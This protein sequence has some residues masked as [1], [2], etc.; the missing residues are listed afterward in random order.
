MR[1][2]TPFALAAS[3]VVA[4]HQPYHDSPAMLA[5]PQR[6]PIDSTVNVH[7]ALQGNGI[8]KRA[9]TYSRRLLSKNRKLAEGRYEKKYR[10]RCEAGGAVCCVVAGA[11]VGAGIGSVT[12]GAIPGIGHIGGAVVGGIPGA[13]AGATIG[14][15][16]AG[17]WGAKKGRAKDERLAANGRQPSANSRSQ[18]QRQ[19]TANGRSQRQTPSEIAR[20]TNI[21][22]T[23]QQSGRRGPRR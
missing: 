17:N 7:R 15:M 3:A 21:R 10:E 18:A 23:P 1:L 13:A 2:L 16:A 22:F 5:H 6:G 4:F 8:Q 19:P 20:Q 14:K 9:R 11:A 12:F